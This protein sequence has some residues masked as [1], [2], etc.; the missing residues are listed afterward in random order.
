[1]GT[2]RG[3]RIGVIEPHLRRYGGIRRM[4]EFANRLVA[5]GHEVTFYLP[6]EALAE[7]CTWMPCHAALAPLAGAAD[8][9]LD[10]VLFN[11]E[12]QW[13]LLE[14]FTGARRRAFYALHDGSLY[15]KEGSWEAARA[16]VD[17]V[18]AN[19]TWTAERLEV[20][21]GRRPQVVLGGVNREV[22]R[23]HGGPKRYPVLCS[24][25]ANKDWKGTETI[26]EAGRLAGVAVEGYAAWDLDQPD[27]GRAYD[28]A[29]CF[30]VGSWYEGFCQPGLEALACGVPLVTTDNGGCREYALDGVTALVVPPRDAPAMAGALRRLLDD[31]VLAKELA[32]NGLDLV[33]EAFDWER[34]TDELVGVLDGIVA[35]PS[36]A[37]DRLRRAVPEQP[38]LSVVV[39]AWDNLLLTQRFVE[40]VR[41]HTD[42]PYELII[43][44]NGSEADAA[45]YARQAADVAV[46]NETNLGFA[47][48][49]NQGLAAAR[50]R[51][52]AFCNNDTRVPPGWAGRLLETAAAHPGAGIVVPAITAANNPV[53]VRTE[54]GEA[55]EVLPPYSAPPAAVLYLAEAEVV[56]ELGAWGEEYEVASG[57]DVDLAFKVWTN[58][59]EIVFDSRVLVDHISKGSASRLDD[60]Q[61]LWARNRRRF[62][63]KWQDP[64]AIVPRVASCPPE[65]HRRNRATASAVA[66]WMERYFN[67]R[68]KQQAKGTGA[69]TAGGGATE[70]AVAATPAAPAA[71]PSLVRGLR[72][73]A[74]RPELVRAP[75]GTVHL[76][77][78]ALRRPVRSGLVAAALQEAFG[79]PRDV[80]ADELDRL[81]EGPPVEVL[82][83]GQGAPFLL[84]GGERCKLKGYP[85]VRR[86][87]P[88]DVKRFPKG[89]P[90]DL[91]GANVSRAQYRR[92]VSGRF[93]LERA[94]AAGPVRVLKGGVR[95][96]GRRLRR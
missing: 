5:R 34:R 10:L 40:S 78:A 59:L 44:D 90:L 56:R 6:D 72:P 87:S 58:D 85:E 51:W 28:A 63:E 14:R 18:L 1:M 76:I 7:G 4:V 96:L 95:R 82:T 80:A 37:P 66:E 9:E 36:S 79:A 74:G 35:A 89:A 94:R 15:D 16:P 68:D 71:R 50:G 55:V 21:V 20:A 26:L 48:G 17:A 39:L 86:V 93:Q 75:G 45:D 52:V 8:A 64:R 57:E 54:P 19:S 73:G 88:S 53:N 25:I 31:E 61:G 29:S 60:W 32:A 84:V 33:A 81:D 43:V 3:M 24:G 23:P 77:E 83:T 38:V 47:K 49:M 41:Q 27:L 69:A 12:P 22:F 62:L 46:M 13:Y 30:A 42:V 70:G 11:H 67:M 65:R 92:A 91:A 2:G